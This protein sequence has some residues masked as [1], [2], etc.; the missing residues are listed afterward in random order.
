MKPCILIVIL[1]FLFSCGKQK[2]LTE[3]TQAPEPEAISF[4]G[5]PLF[6][7]PADTAALAK[8]DS[9]ILAIKAKG[10]LMEDDFVEIGKQLVGTNRYK[11][12][13]NTYTDGLAKYPDSY[14]LLRL[15]GHR[16]I[17]LRQLA[18]SMDDLARAEE[19]IRTQPDVMEYGLDGKPTA[20]YRHQIWY[21][22][23][24]DNYLN[25]D[26]AQAAAAFEKAV[27]TGGNDLKNIVGAS[28]WL[29]NCYMRLGQ[30]EKAE[31]VIKTIT[32]DMDT[33][34]ELAYFKR[35]MLYKGVITP[36]QL[37]DVGMPPEKMTV[38]EITKLYG[39]ANWYA[40][41]GDKDKAR[42]LYST[43]LKSNAWPGFAYAAS[44][45]DIVDH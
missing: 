39:L 38:Q 6:A 45:K 12:A 27:A 14:K 37:I 4:S 25:M 13:L 35:I 22:I 20:T 24:V 40:Y 16:Y 9:A 17:T 23:G 21:H 42:V 33:D 10:E 3:A 19:L 31:A 5:K 15:R 43:V 1:V 26:Y 36:E 41:K 7:T 2:E 11:L 28:D 44:E 18:K 29:Y 8:A 32:P 30:K 34:R